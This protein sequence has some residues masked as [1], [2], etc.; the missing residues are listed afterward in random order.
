MNICIV[1]IA[2]VG[3]KNTHCVTFQQKGDNREILPL[4]YLFNVS[5]GYLAVCASGI[6]ELEVS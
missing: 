5:I 1:C 4:H 3:V 2:A 6:Y